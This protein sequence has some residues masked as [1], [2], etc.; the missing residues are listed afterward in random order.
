MKN[1]TKLTLLIFVLAMSLISCTEKKK[2]ESPMGSKTKEKEVLVMVQEMQQQDLDK[3]VNVIGKLEGI[4]DVDLSSE[5]NG[6][7]IEIYKKL[8]DWVDKGDAIGRIDNTDVK[9]MFLQSQASLLAAEANL[10][11]ANLSITASNKLYEENK[12]SEKE[13]LQAKSSLK[14]AQAGYNGALANSESARKNL[15]NSQFTAPV[16]GYIAELKLEVG[17]M[18]N[19]GMK[20]AGIVN[21]N[22]LI[23]RTGVS[24]SDISFVKKGNDVT[25]KYYGK[26]YLGK[27]TGIGIRP[28]T[29]GNNYPIEI[30]LQNPNLELFPGMIVEG[31]IYSHTFENVLYTSIENLREK[32][33]K[34]FVYVIN[35]ENRAEIRIIELG[36]KVA[37]N[38]IIKSGL[39]ENDKLVIDGIDSLSDSTLVEVKSGFN[40]Q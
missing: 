1:I 4:T 24:E 11:T 7:V 39:Q 19:M 16:A 21:S 2:S 17:E 36:E 32:Y 30:V 31:Q 37:N 8:G 10:E 27:V 13:F 26:E 6:K 9:N 29:G 34:Q 25:I 3:Y 15:E 5:T 14:S 35:N 40:L 12:I 22:K 20:I 18:V 28:V 38:V 23:I 33:D